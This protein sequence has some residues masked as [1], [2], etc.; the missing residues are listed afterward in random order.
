MTMADEQLRLLLEIKGDL[1]E[2]YGI[3]SAVREEL[4][5]H[6]IEDREALRDNRE[7][8]EAIGERVGS[9]ER[10]QAEAAG[11]MR[12]R[13][14]GELRQAGIVAALIAGAVTALGNLFPHWWSR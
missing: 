12:Y 6:R 4:A 9:I 8:L 13:E 3:V 10:H 14:R 1:G 5:A 2:T 11:A 7:R